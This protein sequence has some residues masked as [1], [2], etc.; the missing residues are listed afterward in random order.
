E[1]VVDLVRRLPI[2][3][4]TRLLDVGCGTGATAAALREFGRV[5]AAD[6]SP[7]ALER[8]RRRGLTELIPARAEDLPL[9]DGSIDVIV[10]TDIIEHVDDDLA[11]LRE[12]RRVLCAGGH[13][14]IS[15]P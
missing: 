11:A 1:L 12:F 6:F 2:G 9:Q 3:T 5:T 10:A 7:L 15:V 8:C 13:A 14:V 4:A